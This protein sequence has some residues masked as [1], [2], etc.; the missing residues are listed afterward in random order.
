LSAE[1]ELKI[2]VAKRSPGDLPAGFACI[3]RR[4][5]TLSLCRLD[6]SCCFSHV[7]LFLD[8]AESLIDQYNLNAASVSWHL[9]SK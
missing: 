1:K 5:L 7:R 9:R 2:P 4:A 8:D 3:R 6:W